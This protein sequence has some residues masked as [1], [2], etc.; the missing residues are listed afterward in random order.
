MQ[1]GKKARLAKWFDGD[2]AFIL[3]IDQGIPRG[4]AP[5]IQK[6]MAMWS[7][8]DS[9]WNAL[10]LQQGQVLANEEL[11][12]SKNAIPFIIKLTSNSKECAVSTRR[13]MITN[14]ERAVALGA[15]GVAMNLFI[16][17]EFEANHLTQI[18]EVVNDCERFGMPLMVL[19]NPAQKERNFT[20]EH[21]AYACLVASEMGADIVKSEHPGTVEGQKLIVDSCLCPVLV[22]ESCLSYDTAG[23]IQTAENVM[24]AGGAGMCLGDRMWSEKDPMALARKIREIVYR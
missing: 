8:I 12:T 15:S 16:G 18:G 11:F 9:P 23:T 20:A 7:N 10:L 13:S 1:F 4:I 5:Q 21:L 6:N 2:R 3:A 22:E 17:S 14:V 19:A 24:A